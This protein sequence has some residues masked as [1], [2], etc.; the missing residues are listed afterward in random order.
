MHPV[1][2]PSIILLRSKFPAVTGWRVNQ[3]GGDRWVRRWGPED[4]LVAC[5]TARGEVWRL[6]D[7]AFA[8]LSALIAGATLAE[9][10]AAGLRANA[11][12]DVAEINAVLAASDIVVEVKAGKRSRHWPH[13]AGRMRSRSTRLQARL[14]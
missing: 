1:L 4:A 10:A 11:E 3:P 13:S 9:A 8:F 14:R 7:G 6:P 12:F 5:T 2:H